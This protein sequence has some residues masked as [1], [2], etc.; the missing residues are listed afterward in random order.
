MNKYSYVANQHKMRCFDDM[1][2]YC[3]IIHVSFEV[4]QKNP[5]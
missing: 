2:D 5:F 1:N 3:N 4:D